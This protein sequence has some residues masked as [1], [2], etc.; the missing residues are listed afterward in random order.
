MVAVLEPPVTRPRT[1]PRDVGRSADRPNDLPKPTRR[2]VRPSTPVESDERQIL[3]APDV[4]PVGTF[5]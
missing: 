1:S 2:E 4:V 3:P 5:H